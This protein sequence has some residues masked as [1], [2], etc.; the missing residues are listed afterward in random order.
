VDLSAGVCVNAC[1]Y[2]SVSMCVYCGHRL[3]IVIF[4]SVSVGAC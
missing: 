3:T 4:K 2:M 1:V